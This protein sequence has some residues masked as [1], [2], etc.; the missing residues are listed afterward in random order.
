MGM[1]VIFLGE[2]LGHFYSNGD[3]FIGTYKFGKADGDGQYTWKN[4]SV[5]IGKFTNGMKHGKGKWMK[6]RD[7]TS[8]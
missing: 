3:I 8:N 7:A 2:F 1:E 6:S 5:Y 4:G